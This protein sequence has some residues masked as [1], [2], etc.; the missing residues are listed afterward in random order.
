MDSRRYELA[1]LAW[2]N[3]I[4][5]EP[6]GP[7]ATAQMAWAHADAFLDEFEKR[8]AADK[9]TQEQCNEKYGICRSP[10]TSFR[11]KMECLGEFIEKGGEVYCKE[12]GSPP[13]TKRKAKGFCEGR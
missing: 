12:C 4:R 11:N 9:K 5:N 2:T 3:L 7:D 8:V 10:S 1:K 6:A 13:N